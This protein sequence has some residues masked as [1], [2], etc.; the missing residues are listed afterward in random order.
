M[1]LRHLFDLSRNKKKGILISSDMLT[2]SLAYSVSTFTLFGWGKFPNYWPAHLIT[3]SLLA[4]IVF[5][6]CGLYTTMIRYLGTSEIIKL[7]LAALLSMVC[8]IAVNQ[9]NGISVEVGAASIFCGLVIVITIGTRLLIAELYVLVN[10]A[11]LPRV[12]IYGI[13][14]PGDQVLQVLRKSNQHRVVAV[15][16]DEG[17]KLVGI[18]VDGV[19]VQGASCLEDII[20]KKRIEEVHITV[21]E[22]VKGRRNKAIEKLQ[23]FPVKI[24]IVIFTENE[25]EEVIDTHYRDLDIED[26]LGAEEIDPIRSL[27]DQ[28]VKNKVVLITAAGSCLGEELSRLI[29]NMSPT[30]LVLLDSSGSRL[31]DL[32][33]E[34]LEIEA[35][36]EK[37]IK[38]TTV[39]EE[40][41]SKRRFNKIFRT[42]KVDTIYHLDAHNKVPMM[43]RNVIAAITKNIVGTENCIKAA[44]ESNVNNFV[45]IS[46]DKVVRP[47]NIV[48]VTKR[49]SEQ[50]VQSLAKKYI[51]NNYC[52]VRCGNILD[53]KN[54]VVNLFKRQINSNG[55]VSITHP[56]MSRHFTSVR[57]A[58]QL[59]IQA[60]SLAKQGEIFILDMGA[61]IKI[62]TLL[63][64]IVRMMGL[65]IRTKEDASGTVEIKYIGLRAGEKIYEELCTGDNPWGTEHP[66]VMVADEVFPVWEEL[67]LM[68]IGLK[69]ACDSY[70]C[71]EVRE[72]LV[73]FDTGYSPSGPVLDS[74]WRENTKCEERVKN[75][76]IP[77]FPL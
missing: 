59:I 76:I 22:R 3:I 13:G 9:V 58:A 4:F 51:R 5:S 21:P 54:S 24:K 36:N 6:S 43:E 71:E 25:R 73:K 72:A 77:V 74:V 34:L 32:M 33:E 12:L 61:P 50:I 45:L 16:V 75:N 70:D 42:F 23:E 37:K 15:V 40:A 29:A 63:E 11:S 62:I 68:L 19:K 53:S 52:A 49:I 30:R 7:I 57:N 44:H 28:C 17:D 69:K 38:I 35:A 14:E 65:K 67:D 18:S 31:Y 2:L 55:I 27:M 1:L 64:M 56:E 41:P 26:L 20:E 46:S 8:Y 60:G 47:T 66:M 10:S 48:G 39:L